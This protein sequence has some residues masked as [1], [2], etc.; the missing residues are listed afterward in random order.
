MGRTAF[1]LYR[2]VLPP[3]APAFGLVCSE[4]LVGSR[5]DSLQS[6]TPQLLLEAETTPAQI[7]TPVPSTPS[8]TCSVAASVTSQG[9]QQSESVTELL[10]SWTEMT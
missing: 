1:R 2:A 7:E 6:W 8:T 5:R 3:G 4:P 10:G 9:G